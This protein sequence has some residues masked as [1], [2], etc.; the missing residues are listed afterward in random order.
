MS[1]LPQLLEDDVRVFDD[2]LREFLGQ[3]SAMTA[4]VVDKGGPKLTPKDETYHFVTPPPGQTLVEVANSV[5]DL[6]KQMNSNRA[7]QQ[8]IGR[9]VVDRTGLDGQYHMAL[10]ADTQPGPD[11]RGIKID[12]DYFSALRELGLRLDAIEET[13]DRIVVDS[14][15]RPTPN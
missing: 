10:R 15:S 5:P 4:L 13:F 11:G 12:I 14:A 3:T 6:V 7:A 9:P 2:S 8:S 1:T